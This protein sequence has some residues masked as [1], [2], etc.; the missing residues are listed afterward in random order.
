[1]AATSPQAV[2]TSGKAVAFSG[3]AVAVGLSG[4]LFMKAPALN[5]IGIG[6]SLVVLSSVLYALTFLPAV[7]GMLGPRINA[8]SLGRLFERLGLRSRNRT[9]SH[10]WERVAQGVMARPVLVLVPVLLFLLAAGTPF[11]RVK[12]AVPGAE[13]LPA[14]LESRDTYV[15]IQREFPRGETTPINVSLRTQEQP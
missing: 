1:M 5:S 4:L 7:L 14:G 2:A 10:R 12:Q 8:L 13:V 9:P 11:L 3:F 15:A 6:G